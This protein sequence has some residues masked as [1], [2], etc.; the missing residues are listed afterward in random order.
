MR[1]LQQIIKRLIIGITGAMILLIFSSWVLAAISIKGVVA[2]ESIKY[3]T[4]LMI[5]LSTFAGIAIIHSGEA[6]IKLKISILYA[7]V[8]WVILLSINALLLGGKF[9]GV[10]ETLILLLG[11][12]IAMTLLGI[13]LRKGRKKSY[14]F[15]KNR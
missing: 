8:L 9:N 1:R 5:I 6:E 2:Y 12:S 15:R 11:S 13:R 3:C 14:Y 10:A 7:G 4:L